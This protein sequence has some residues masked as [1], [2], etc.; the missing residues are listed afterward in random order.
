M[1]KIPEILCLTNSI[2]LSSFS[3]GQL[4]IRRKN[5]H[6][7]ISHPLFLS[8]LFVLIFQ[9]LFIIGNQGGVMR[10]NLL[11]IMSNFYQMVCANDSLRNDSNSRKCQTSFGSD[12][13]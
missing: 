5:I 13:Q 10:K 4:I 6:L 3:H 1:I 2:R 11:E 8:I 7:K 9:L 12:F